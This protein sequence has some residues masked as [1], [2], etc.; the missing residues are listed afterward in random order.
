MLLLLLRRER[1]R[2][3]RRALA[4]ARGAPHG[5]WTEPL[6]GRALVGGDG[7]D[8]EVVAQQLVVVV[9]VGDGRVQ[10]L[11]P[12][13]GDRARRVRQDGARLGN[14]LAADVV[15]DQA[16]LAGRR[17]DVLGVRVH[18]RTAVRRRRWLG[19]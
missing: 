2:Q 5:A 11:L 7:Q 10:E 14:G 6:E 15:A 13:L 3:V 4:D 19:L 1:D 9:G 16:G 12:L 8:A 17:A 18:D